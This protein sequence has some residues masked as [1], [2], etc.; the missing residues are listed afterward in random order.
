MNQD[1][2]TSGKYGA[3]STGTSNRYINHKV[4]PLRN[5]GTS[6]SP[7]LGGGIRSQQHT[8]AGAGSTQ[9]SRWPKSGAGERTSPLRNNYAADERSRSRSKSPMDLPVSDSNFRGTRDYRATTSP[10]DQRRTSPLR[11]KTRSRSPPR[12]TYDDAGAFD[13]PERDS[14]IRP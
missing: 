8:G 13:M 12:Q 10:A 11:Q 4:A 5:P 3:A 7:A 6:K 14:I 2:Q 1:L 9:E